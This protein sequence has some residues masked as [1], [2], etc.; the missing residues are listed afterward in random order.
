MWPSMFDHKETLKR[1]TAANEKQHVS[2]E[3][4]NTS[5]SLLQYKALSN[6]VLLYAIRHSISHLFSYFHLNL[7]SLLFFYQLQLVPLT[8]ILGLVSVLPNLCR[9]DEIV[10]PFLLTLICWYCKCFILQFSL[11]E[12]VLCSFSRSAR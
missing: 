2:K 12:N 9:S 6:R 8:K 7:F 10:T 1:K 4:F 5:C 3:Q 11:P